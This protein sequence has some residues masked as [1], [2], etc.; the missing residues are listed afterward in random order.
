MLA[1]HATLRRSVD[2]EWALNQVAYREGDLLPAG[3]FEIESGVAEIDVFCGANLIV[4]GPAKL[5]FESDWS[6]RLLEGRVRANVPPVA[7]G[8]VVKAADSNIIDLGTEFAV[9]MDSSNTRLQVIDGEVKLS[10][11]KFDGDHFF[12]GDGHWINGSG[13][14]NSGF[15]ELATIGEVSKR[16][17]DATRDRYQAWSA[18]VDAIAADERVIAYYPI[19]RTHSTDLDRTV[20][21]VAAAKNSTDGQ[22]VGPVKVTAGRFGTESAGVEFDRFGSRVRAKIDGDFDALTLACWV[23]IDSLPNV[24]NALLMSD[25]YENGEPHWQIHQDGRLMLSVM[26]DESKGMERF[27]E[28]DQRMV[29]SAGL[30]R[31]YYSPPIWDASKS[32]QWFHLVSVF[33]PKSS[34]VRHFV[35]GQ[36]VHEQVIEEGFA[37]DKL[38]I[39][40]AEIGNWGQ[41]F[42]QTPW[43]S[44]RNF[45]GV[46]DEMMICSSA[47]EPAEVKDLYD[48]GKPVGYP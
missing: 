36:Q 44:V 21:N 38:R 12:S 26:V 9:E 34:R 35:N 39:G 23:R 41:P 24:Y 42:R 31:I 16:Y 43:F 15:E 10:G 30:A 5:N 40:A 18:G 29:R 7:R 47:L 27:S 32:G 14:E 37:V 8:F 20:E 46:I 13:D 33:D 28:K 1:G 48:Q 6:V 19:A 4:E 22:L 17:D 25:G 45:D 3:R 11:G 2:L